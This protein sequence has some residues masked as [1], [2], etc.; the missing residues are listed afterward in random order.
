MNKSSKELL[1][2]TMNKD[3]NTAFEKLKITS[4]ENEDSVIKQGDY[5]HFTPLILS[6]IK[7]IGEKKKRPDPLLSMTT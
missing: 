3:I 2:K 6:V 1:K 5:L 4:E 7:D